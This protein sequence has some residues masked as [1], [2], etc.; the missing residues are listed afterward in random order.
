MLYTVRS[1]VLFIIL[2][3]P[4]WVGIIF[5][6]YNKYIITIYLCEDVTDSN[7]CIGVG[8]GVL[9]QKPFSQKYI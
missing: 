8:P 7:A 2:V 6:V 3:F 9:G 5:P 4:Q 1:L